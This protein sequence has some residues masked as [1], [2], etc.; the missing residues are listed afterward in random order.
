MKRRYVY[1]PL[2]VGALTPTGVVLALSLAS[3]FSPTTDPIVINRRARFF[4]NLFWRSDFE[5]TLL[6]LIPFVVLI[7][8]MKVVSDSGSKGWRQECIFGA[9]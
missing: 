3:H 4:N 7:G 6:A 8:A 1:I 9:A 5:I 2:L